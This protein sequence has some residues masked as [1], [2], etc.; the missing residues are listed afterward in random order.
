M[1]NQIRPRSSNALPGA[2]KSGSM[3][4]NIWR[5][6]KYYSRRKKVYLRDGTAL[7]PSIRL[8]DWLDSACGDQEAG[9]DL[10]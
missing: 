7:M 2:G 6:I 9:R 4:K 1:N 10:R 8:Y 3:I 5:W